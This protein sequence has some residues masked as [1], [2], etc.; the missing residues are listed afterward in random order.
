M[1]RA[2]FILII[3]LLTSLRSLAQEEKALSFKP[4]MQRSEEN[5]SHLKEESL[6]SWPLRWKYIPFGSKSFLSLGG[7]SRSLYE[8]FRHRDFREVDEDRNGW[9]FQR[10]LF[11]TDLRLGNFR[12]FVQLQ[13]L[14]H[15]FSRE[16][17]SPVDRDDFDIHQLFAEYQLSLG[18]GKLITRLGR[19]ELSLGSQRL[20]S[21]R[22][23]PNARLA[24]NAIKTN[25]SWASNQLTLFYAEPINNRPG[26]F[27]NEVFDSEQTWGAYWV[28][29][30]PFDLPFQVD[31]YYI[32]MSSSRRMYEQ[33]VAD[34]TR[35]SIGTRLWGESGGFSYNNEFI[36]QFGSW[37]DGDISAYTL[38]FD[39]GYQLSELGW[40]PK[41]GLKTEIVSGDQSTTDNDLNTFNA[42]YPRGAYFGLIALIGPANLIDFHPSFSLSPSERFS[43][44]VDWDIFWRHTTTD[45]VYGPNAQLFRE[46]SSSEENYLGHQPGFEMAFEASNWWE[47]SLEGSWFFTSDFWRDTG[48]YDNVLHF[49]V[50][51]SWKF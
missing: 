46:G 7:D 45:G 5:T 11:H 2:G 8:Y 40:K 34:E 33:G 35:H 44:T 14:H 1:V 16:P 38:S 27:D 23:G 13:S 15:W 37:G 43:F 4:S 32:G 18:Q 9:L 48:E 51:S 25:I 24:F 22:E 28:S 12:T 41:L 10:F 36:Y 19:Q 20:F 26:S 42:L 39:L 49:A 31:A 29:P 47:L 50:V 21:F 3:L 6:T 17:S 30:A